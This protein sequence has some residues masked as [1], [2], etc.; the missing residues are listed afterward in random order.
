MCFPSPF[1][2]SPERYSYSTS[3]SSSKRTEGSCR[4]R[5]QSGRPVD[6]QQGQWETGGLCRASGRQVGSAGPRA[7]S[8][9]SL[10]PRHSVLVSQTCVQ[11][12]HI[13]L[14]LEVFCFILL[15]WPCGWHTSAGGPWFLVVPVEYSLNFFQCS[16][17]PLAHLVCTYSQPAT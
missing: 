10:V 9:P 16:A 8:S 7:L 17:L 12:Q 13:V 15:A 1:P 11:K 2:V 4:R 3:S 6:A 5:R 14:F